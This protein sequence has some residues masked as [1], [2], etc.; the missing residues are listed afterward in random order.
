LGFQDLGNS[1]GGRIGTDVLLGQEL[2][3]ELSTRNVLVVDRALID[4]VLAELKLGASS[5]AD[6]DTQLRLGRLTAAR[7]IAVGRLFN[8]NG[9]AL[10]SFRLIDTETSQVVLNRT[11]DAGAAVDPIAMSERLARL[12]ASEVLG[13]YPAK[14]R[15]VSLDGEAV[16]INLGK[17]NGIATGDV[18]NVLGEG[19]P[20]VFNGKVLGTHDTVLGRLRVSAVDDQMAYAVPLERSGSWA[21]NLR[22]VQTHGAAQ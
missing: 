12:A 10:V 5:L 11:E 14:G 21:A 22:L 15:I 3:R 20:V 18:F 1:L 19:T 17:K 9:K 6:P 2:A 8:L 16:V 7:L 13:K 4:K